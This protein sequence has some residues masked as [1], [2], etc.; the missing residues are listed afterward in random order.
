MWRCIVTLH[1]SVRCSDS[2]WQHVLGLCV[3][4][5]VCV[6]HSRYNYLLHVYVHTHKWIIG[7]LIT[8]VH[9]SDTFSWSNEAKSL[10]WKVLNIS[11]VNL[12]TN[13]T[14]TVTRIYQFALNFELTYL[15]ERWICNSVLFPWNHNQIKFYHK[16][17]L[18]KGRMY[19][20]F[21]L[22]VNGKISLKTFILR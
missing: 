15:V 6:C 2:G 4:L 19:K 22:L 3:C 11:S 1:S 9:K 8:V 14:I 21:Q 10:F 12:S 13:L 16:T 20:Y 5:C 7:L 17:P 18:K